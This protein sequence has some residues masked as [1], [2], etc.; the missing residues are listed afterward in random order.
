METMEARTPQ[1]GLGLSVVIITKNEAHHLTDCLASVDFA[2]EVII[3][4]SGS[5]DGTVELAKA[6]GAQVHSTS[7]WPGF[8]A[9]KN[10][11]LDLASQPWVLSID[12]DE[13]VTPVL[14]DDIIATLVRPSHQAYQMARL[15]EFCQ[16]PIYHSGWWPDHVLRLFRRDR[17]R[18]NDAQV[19]ERVV[20]TQPVATLHGHLLHY[21]YPDLDALINKINRY[22]SD[23]ANS[24]AKKGK[25]ASVYS[26]VTHSVW[27]FIRIYFLRKG[28]LDGRY[29]FVLAV[30]AASGSFYRYAKL[31]MLNDRARAVSDKQ[32]QK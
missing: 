31:M 18:F 29:G 9:Q 11:A 19:H 12:A 15:S 25:R 28:F 8:G 30:T 20:T 14:R 7:D 4:D 1:K 21:P 24:M 32:D 22:S 3:V 17:A 13:R 2:D 10:R 26:A 6:L 23:A 5:T 16:Q 27:T